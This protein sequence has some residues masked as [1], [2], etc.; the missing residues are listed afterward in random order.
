MA[1]L[2]QLLESGCGFAQ[3]MSVVAEYL[4]S[5]A[6]CPEFLLLFCSRLLP[7]LGPAF[8]ALL[9]PTPSVI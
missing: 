9:G 4:A 7:G 1:L 6:F 3:P 8:Q 5:S 2:V